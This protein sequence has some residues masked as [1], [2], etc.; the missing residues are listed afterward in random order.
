MSESATAGTTNLTVNQGCTVS[1]IDFPCDN[2]NFAFPSSAASCP[3]ITSSRQKAASNTLWSEPKLLPSDFDT[4]PGNQDSLEDEDSIGTI[5]EM[6]SEL[7]G[8][9]DTLDDGN[10]GSVPV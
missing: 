6:P 2:S 3:P 5:D 4:F 9:N 8:T 1:S 10:F 7:P